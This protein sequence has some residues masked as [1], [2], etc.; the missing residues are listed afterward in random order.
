MHHGKF[1]YLRW[2]YA[3]FLVGAIGGLVVEGVRLAMAA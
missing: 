3:L 2:S 1:R